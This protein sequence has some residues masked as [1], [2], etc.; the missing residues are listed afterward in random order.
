MGK[1]INPDLLAI[2]GRLRDLRV[3]RTEEETLALLMDGKSIAE[4]AAYKL[5]PQA[6]IK[7][8]IKSLKQKLGVKNLVS[9]G[10]RAAECGMYVPRAQGAG[11]I[12]G[13]TQIQD[14]KL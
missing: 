10:A 11:L 1:I 6:C 3:L 12:S 7:A 13:L 2:N 8:H 9:L 4:A 14:C 5:R